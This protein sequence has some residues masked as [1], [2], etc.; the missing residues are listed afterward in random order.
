MKV[1]VCDNGSHPKNRESI[2]KMMLHNNIECFYGNDLSQIDDTYNIAIC[3]SQFFPP[4]RFPKQ[5]KVIYGPQ[6]FVFPGHSHDIHKY[7]YDPSRFFYNTLAS[8]NQIIHKNVAPTLSLTFAPI[9]YG[10]DIENIKEVPPVSQ[11]NKIM[12]YFKHRHPSDLDTVKEFLNARGQEYIVISY[13]S[14][15]DADFKNKL[16]ESRFV[17]WIGSHESQGF[18]FQETQASNMPILLWDVTSM[19]DEYV[20]GRPYGS[21]SGN[22]DDL[23]ATTA[24]CW[25]DECG[26]KFFR[27]EELAKAYNRM[28]DQVATFTPR[29][30]IAE[31]LSLKAAFDNLLATIG[32]EKM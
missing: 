26:I 25:S 23:A 7:I 5:C 21:P 6:F 12:I 30:Y 15:N 18:A 13:G 2:R 10:I 24:N 31:R 4:D 19:R 8:W 27:K 16:Q 11:R 22:P 1:Y 28:N 17:I 32:L 9:P 20:G 29:K 3:V 14:Y